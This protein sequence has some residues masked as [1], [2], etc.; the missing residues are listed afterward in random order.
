MKNIGSVLLSTL[1]LLPTLLLLTAAHVPQYDYATGRSNELYHAEVC[2]QGRIAVDVAVAYRDFGALTTSFGSSTIGIEW[3]QE[4]AS[5]SIPI[6]M[7]RMVSKA[8][9]CI[10]HLRSPTRLVSG[11]RPKS[12]RPQASPRPA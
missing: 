4:S 3:I 2:N 6:S 12:N 9:R 11:A 10:W 5:S 7:R 8:S 1:F